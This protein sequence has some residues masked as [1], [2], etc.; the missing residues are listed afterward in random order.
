M[1]PVTS[2]DNELPSTST[3]SR[4]TMDSHI[5]RTMNDSD[6]AR[7][8]PR[9]LKAARVENNH[10]HQPSEMRECQPYPFFYYKD[11]STEEDPDPFMPLIAPGRVVNFVA[12]MHSV[13]SR[14]ELADIVAWMPH[15]RAWKILKPREFEI[16]V[17]PE[18]F[19]HSKLSS[20]IRQANG[21]GF[22]RIGQGPDK[23]AYYHEQFLRGLP[24][25]CKTM[26]RP[27]VA[28]KRALDATQEP[29]LYEISKFRPVPEKMLTEDESIL[30][31]GGPK[32][33]MPVY[34]PFLS[35]NPS[36]ASTPSEHL[37]LN[38]FEKSISVSESL[39]FRKTTKVEHTPLPVDSSV[40]PFLPSKTSCSTSTSSFSG[41]N[42]ANKLSALTMADQLAFQVPATLPAFD[43]AAAA[44]FAA[45]FAFALSQQ[46]F[47]TN[48][49]MGNRR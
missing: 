38:A 49:Y 23:G 6:V 14:P 18:Y 10:H 36:L 29:N 8:S 28:Q 42:R 33:R 16:R 11:F 45:G 39:H 44:Q 31:R 32:A 41:S 35:S 48:L 27:G 9:P 24:H 22:R 15:G 13:L 40:K 21:W 12:K 34:Q 1:T 25:L 43:P 47:N 7:G 2:S 3:T 20:F 26:K 17:L 4:N 30:F 19:E 46:P 5:K 37:K